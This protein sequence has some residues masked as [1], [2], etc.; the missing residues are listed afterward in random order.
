MFP[1]GEVSGLA[2][3]RPA[4]KTD[5][6]NALNKEMEKDL[7]SILISPLDTS[8]IAQIENFMPETGAISGKKHFFKKI[9]IWQNYYI[10][11][12]IAT[13]LNIFHKKVIFDKIFNFF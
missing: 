2:S 11:L 3:G 7:S 13:F 1:L 6:S 8:L 9:T 12:G 5:A 4:T 10:F